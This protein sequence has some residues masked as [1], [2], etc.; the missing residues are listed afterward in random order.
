MSRPQARY[1]WAND[2]RELV[3]AVLFAA[4]VIGVWMYVLPWLLA[5]FGG[6]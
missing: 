3:L 1:D 2:V 4:T 5:W 6:G